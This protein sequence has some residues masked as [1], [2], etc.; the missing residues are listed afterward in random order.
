[1]IDTSYLYSLHN[2]GGAPSIRDISSQ[3]FGIKLPEQHDSVQDAMASLRAALYIARNGSHPPIH[4]TRN[5]TEASSLLCHKIPD[6][7]TEE[8]IHQMFVELT[9]IIPTNVGSIVRASTHGAGKAT[10]RFA[11][12]RHADLAFDSLV[13]PV[14]HEK[15]N[16]EQKRVYLKGGGHLCVRKF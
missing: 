9:S 4:R 14:R 5:E 3:V 15:S 10:I 2:E 7:C 6:I 16:R 12:E 11:S 13:G 1:M 8:H